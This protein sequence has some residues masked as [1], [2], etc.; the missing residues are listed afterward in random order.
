MKDINTFKLMLKKI[1]DIMNQKQKKRFW[2]AFI[3]IFFGALF[4]LLGVSVMLPFIQALLTPEA[5]MSKPYI[6]LGMN[7]LGLTNSQQMLFMVGVG[8]IVI[9]IIKNVYLL[10]SIYIQ[11]DY[12][13]RL[14]KTLSVL[15]LKSYM[16]RP[17]EFFANTN[18]GDLLR[19]LTTDVDGVCTVVELLFKFMTESFVV[20][21]IAVYLFIT[22]FTMTLG[23]SFVGMAT[24]VILIFGV[25][26]NISKMGRK[27]ATASSLNYKNATQAIGGIKDI[28]VF[29]KKSHFVKKYENSYNNRRIANTRYKFVSAI[30]ERIIEGFCLSGIIVMVLIRLK[31]GVNVEAFVPKMAV[32]AVAAF[33]LLPSI[34]RITGYITTFI[35]FRPTLENAHENIMAAKAITNRDVE[36]EQ[37]EEEMAMF[38]NVLEVKEITWKYAHAEEETLREL[39]MKVSK[40]EA[41]GII[42][43]SGSGKS[44]L[45]D[46]LLQLYKP[47]MGVV[48][49]DGRDISMYRKVWNRIMGYVPQ[50]VFILDDSIRNN[51]AFGVETP[52]DEKIWD[53]LRK[54][55]LDEFVKRL[56]E[57]LDTFVGERG[58][59]FSGGQRQRIAI[60]RA[61]YMQPQILI[62]DEATSALDN[63]TE[64]AVMDAVE[65]LHGEI[66]LIIIAHRLTTLRHCDKIYE[67]RNG[68]AIERDVAEVMRLQL[69]KGANS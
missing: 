47:Q 67:V 11:V 34:S 3:V 57:G 4:E 17:Y 55:K 13:N 6:N 30:P 37:I 24:L 8:I 52:D 12:T 66:T 10:L 26:K 15:M 31:T 62:L 41:V 18:S 46:I 45:A 61:L 25:K 35:F 27:S 60:A 28:L 22:D 59:R 51:I 16:E 14:N 20:V 5:L 53:V 19:G 1:I 36:I 50:S 54:A 42:G 56:P 2:C 21:L 38:D 64:S 69:L 68:E 44:T 48:E 39:S 29:N 63:E 43:E 33:R 7:V 9:Y 49:I 32:F 23:I 58:V 40:G 65:N